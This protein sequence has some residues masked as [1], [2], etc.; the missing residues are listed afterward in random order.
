MQQAVR[1]T[2]SKRNANRSH[3]EVMEDPAN[4]PGPRTRRAL[5]I[6]WLNLWLEF[7]SLGIRKELAQFALEGPRVHPGSLLVWMHRAFEISLHIA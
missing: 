3:L 6:H 4:E 7:R 5:L 2:S 1:G